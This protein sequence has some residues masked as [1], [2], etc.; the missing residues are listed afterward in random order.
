MIMHFCGIIIKPIKVSITDARTLLGDELVNRGVADW[1][2]TDDYRER[3]FDEGRTVPLDKFKVMFEGEEWLAK[4]SVDNERKYF[5]NDSWAFA[6]ITD[7]YI[8]ELFL[9]EDFWEFSEYPEHRRKLVTAYVDAYKE[10][11]T[12]IINELLESPTQQYDV[13]LLDYHN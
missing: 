5:S 6:V 4:L 10:A 8:D 9:A 13:V 3:V 12:S 7:D 2:S 1:Y 11:T